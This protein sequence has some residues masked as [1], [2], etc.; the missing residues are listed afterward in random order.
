MV[1]LI[2]FISSSMA[3]FLLSTAGFKYLM[4]RHL[5]WGNSGDDPIFSR[6]LLVLAQL[7]FVFPLYYH[8]YPVSLLELCSPGIPDAY[9]SKKTKM[10]Q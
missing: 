7:P 3:M 1:N 2:S 5:Y 9:V 4:K 6:V 10:S 8:G